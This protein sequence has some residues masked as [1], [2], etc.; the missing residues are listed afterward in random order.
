[1]ADGL[2]RQLEGGR[3]W[4]AKDGTRT[5]VIAKEVSGRRYELS[6]HATTLKAVLR[7][8]ERFMADPLRIVPTL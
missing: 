1:M 5:Y 7:H 4:E 3:V 2:G 6:T 8:Y